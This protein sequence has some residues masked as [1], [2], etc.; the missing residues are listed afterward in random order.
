MKIKVTKDLCEIKENEVW[1][2]G[3]Y[4][5]HTVEV[6]LSADFN[7]LVNKVRYFVEDNSYDMLITDN[8]AGVP[9][10]ATLTEGTIKIGV[11]GY[12]ADTDILVQSTSPVN[13][14]ITSGTYTGE[15]D[16]TQP[17]TPTDKEQMETAIQKNTDDITDLKA[18]KQDKLISGVNIKTINN[19][20]ILSS[21]NLTLVTEETDPIFTNSP[22]YS[23]TDGDI[24]Y[25]NNKANVSDIPDVSNFITKDVDNLTYYTKSTDMQN[26]INSAVNTEKVARENADVNLQNQ[27]DA[28]TVSSDVIDILGTYQDLQNYDT[29]HVK[30][31]DIIKVLQ[32]STHNDAMSYY[33][34]VITDHVGAWV[35]V[36]SEGPYYTKS[37]SDILLN[38]KQNEITSNNMLASDLVDDTNQTNQFVTTAE[39]TTWN[40]K[41]DQSDL[42][43][44]VKNTDY[45][46]SSKGGVVKIGG[47]SFNITQSGIPYAITQTYSYY[48]TSMND[49]SF[50]SKG[51]MENVITGKNLETA[52]N[53]VTSISESSTNVQ[54][55]SAKCVYDNEV[56]ITDDYNKKINY[57]STLMNLF[58]KITGTGTS[59]TLNN[60]SDTMLKLGLNANTSQVTTTGRNLYDYT[61]LRGTVNFLTYDNDGWYTAV[62]DRTNQDTAD[63]FNFSTIVSD[64]LE[65]D[66][67]YSIVTEIKSFSTIGNGGSLN[68][69]DR[70]GQFTTGTS[71]LS[72]VGIHVQT[73][74][75]KSSFDDLTSM[76]TSNIY[77]RA[78]SKVTVVFRISVIKGTDVTVDNFVYEPY[79]GGQ[80]A[81]SPSYPQE[82][83]TISGDN[84]VKIINKNLF[85]GLWTG[86][87]SNN[88]IKVYKNVNYKY[89][90]QNQA[91]SVNFRFYTN[92]TSEDYTQTYV[93]YSS[94][95]TPSEDGYI[96]LYKT[97]TS[98]IQCQLEIGTTA[99]TY[100]PHKEQTYP[101]TL[102]DIE[103]CKIGD[104]EDGIRQSTGKNLFDGSI[105]PELYSYN[106]SG[107]KVSDTDLC[108]NQELNNIDFS[109][110]Y[111]SFSSI[112]GSAYV[113]VCEYNSSGTFIKRTLV[114]TNQSLTL[115]S[116]TKKIIFSVNAS[117]AKYFTNLMINE[118][119][120]ALPYEPYGKVWYKYGAIGKVVLNGTE[121]W[122]T[123]VSGVYNRFSTGI[124]GIVSVTGRNA[125]CISNY[126]RASVENGYGIMFH[127]G[128]G[129]YLY[130]ESGITT[131]SQFKT[132]LST[133]NTTIYYPLATPTYTLL[134]DTLQTQLNN[135]Q[136]AL[137]Y[138]TQ[139]NISQTN[140]DLS[141]II[142][143]ETFA[144]IGE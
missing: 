51:T 58:E 22:A 68:V 33:R 74:T 18:N 105:T 110:I 114:N 26:A 23:I 92:T 100:V 142:N 63:Y 89:S 85:D 54:Y 38:A 136:Y 118:G 19:E 99:T 44:Y 77:V 6:D 109:S 65:T 104:Y 10:E 125:D 97:T 31:N 57:L 48:N 143:A 17:L 42:A 64:N 106:S 144:K 133:H 55:P 7:G 132:W 96:K 140:N 62:C 67:T 139:T 116:N 52:N 47:Y 36:G 88:F 5:V 71:G 95:F 141:F 25:W 81:P 41:L 103:L 16:N 3:D 91:D 82:I 131:V 127:I 21:G 13:K 49:A 84:T 102:G 138:D 79:T 43:D 61:D 50:I 76:L 73:S 40:N 2:V 117:S 94:Y 59:I 115:D 60:T 27:I 124:S 29:S 8:I 28:I 120:T 9:Y 121:Y 32:D 123:D 78:N 53:K 72:T 111:V 101:I 69:V 12:D 93:N 86:G 107:V 14:Y 56:N 35:Y 11:Y 108:I 122:D 137:A 128:G 1:N 112:V 130:P 119:T 39:K 30:A 135:M 75:T 70:W 90:E 37:E 34:W 46:S 98:G 45:A 24:T 4:N 83:H 66:T 87:I 126:F 80:P 20:S 129:I 113:R 15:S 134:N